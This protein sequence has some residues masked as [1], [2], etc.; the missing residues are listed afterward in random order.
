MSPLKFV[1]ALLIAFP[2]VFG[3]RAQIVPTTVTV[4]GDVSKPLVL[5]A[6]DFKTMKLYTVNR[7]AHDGVTHTYRGVSLFDLLVQAGAVPGG[8]LKGTAL[9][10]YVVVAA[11]DKYQVV[12]ALPEFN[13]TFCDQV[14][15][16]ANEEDTKPLPADLGPYQ[17]I[18][19][20]DKK[21]ARCV[22]G[23]TSIIVKTATP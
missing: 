5:S 10:K 23:V 21:P 9:S 16:L 14:I 3:C 19:P 15:I 18:I 4:S 1:L 11:R 17:L 12:I 6:G 13:P 7:P 22:W 20:A 8:Q 2:V